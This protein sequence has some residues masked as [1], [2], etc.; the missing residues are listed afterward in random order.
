M[1][2]TETILPT[3]EVEGLMFMYAVDIIEGQGI[4]TVDITGIFIQVDMEGD[5][6]HIKTKIKVAEILV[7][8]DQKLYR[9]Y[10]TLIKKKEHLIYKLKRALYGTI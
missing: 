6:G 7:K 1:D 8:L 10:A 4:P 3:M 9:K 5:W 2:Q